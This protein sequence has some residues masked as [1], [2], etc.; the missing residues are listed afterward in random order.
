MKNLSGYQVV[1][2][3]YILMS[4]PGHGN[5]KQI[6]DNI[7]IICNGLVKIIND[8]NKFLRTRKI[9][10]SCLKTIPT[11]NLVSKIKMVRTINKNQ[12]QSYTSTLKRSFVY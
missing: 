11:L 9:S 1:H 10:N 8:K 2:H 7:K 12:S 5:E 4:C 6:E 3:G